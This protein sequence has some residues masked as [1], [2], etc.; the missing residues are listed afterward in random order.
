MAVLENDPVR[1]SEESTMLMRGNGNRKPANS[2]WQMAL[3]TKSYHFV[4][5][6]NKEKIMR[7]YQ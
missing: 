2:N 4:R 5:F 3:I 7:I 1:Q 6:L